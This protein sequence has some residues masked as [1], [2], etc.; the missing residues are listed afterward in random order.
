VCP[1]P[2]SNGRSDSDS[3]YCDTNAQHYPDPSAD[4]YPDYC[5]VSNL[6]ANTSN[7]GNSNPTTTNCHCHRYQNSDCHPNESS[8]KH[9]YV[10]SYPSSQRYGYAYCHSFSHGK[11]HANSYADDQIHTCERNQFC[12]DRDLTET[13]RRG[14]LV[15]QSRSAGSRGLD[16]LYPRRKPYY[17]KGGNLHLQSD[18]IEA[19][20]VV[21]E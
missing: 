6:N 18:Y 14:G 9:L 1:N 4:R 3:R 10:S 11:S 19:D 21:V 15:F 17:P 7:H 8:N 20:D 16:A 13:L 12:L 5:H 2:D